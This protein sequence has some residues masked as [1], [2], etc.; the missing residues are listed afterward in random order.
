M[1][2]L[3]VNTFAVYPETEKALRKHIVIKLK[4]TPEETGW[5]E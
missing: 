4:F 1:A 2:N 3:I 5:R